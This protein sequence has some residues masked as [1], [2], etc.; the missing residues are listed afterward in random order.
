[1]ELPKRTILLQLNFV[2]QETC[3]TNYLTKFSI[4]VTDHFVVSDMVIKG[5]LSENETF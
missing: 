5:R 3:L 2:F 1:M 4:V